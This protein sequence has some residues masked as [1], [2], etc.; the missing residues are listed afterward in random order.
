MNM[1]ADRYLGE[2]VPPK[3]PILRLYTW[4][5]PAISFGC[6]QNPAKRL[7]LEL[8]ADDDIPV[9]KRPT[10]GRELLHGHD[11]CYTVAWPQEK[12]LTAV[13]AKN[14]FALI[15][16]ALVEAFSNMGIKAEWNEFRNRPK[17]L[18][19]PCFAQVDTGELAVNGKK[20]VGSAQRLFEKCVIQQ[21][22]IPL[23]RPG[24]DLVKYL[25]L[26]EKA[27]IRSIMDE[28]STY[29]A[30]CLGQEIKVEALISPFMT[31]FEGLFGGPAGPA[32]S[33]FVELKGIIA[34]L[35]GTISDD[36]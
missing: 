36:K 4:Q 34:T 2:E 7:M 22:S 9:V 12:N 19:G 30:D 27:R 28:S 35:H 18:E 15:N 33:F 26:A 6:N 29:L 24:V 5:K 23:F 13:E 32:D 16:N 8:C 3:F 31:A 21:G 20:L 17:T 1:E 25:Q 11:I 14:I 10:G